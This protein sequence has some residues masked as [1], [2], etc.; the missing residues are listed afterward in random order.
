MMEVIFPYSLIRKGKDLEIKPY[1]L[2]LDDILKD[3]TI[4]N[5]NKTKLK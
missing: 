5:T 1:L 2:C 4:D 3:P